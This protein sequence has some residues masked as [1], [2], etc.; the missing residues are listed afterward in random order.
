V[1]TLLLG[2]PVLSL[3]GGI[4]A[5]LFIGVKQQGLLLPVLI[6]P[7]YIPALI[8]GTGT[9]LAVGSG[10]PV[11][12]YYAIMGALMLVTLAFA[13]LLTSLALQVGVSQ[14]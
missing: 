9:L 7:L 11:N 8:F 5:A 2:T 1:L 14:V 4:G 12:G 13:P 6:M 10:L 3:L